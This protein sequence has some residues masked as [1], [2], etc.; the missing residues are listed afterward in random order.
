M[1]DIKPADG[2]ITLKDSRQLC[3]SYFGAQPK[4]G[5]TVLYFHGYLSSRLEAA[6]LDKE[7]GELGLSL[8]AFDRSGYGN[9]YPDP[10]RTP[11]NSVSD[12]QQLLEALIPAEEKVFVFAASGEHS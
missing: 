7:A 3:Y 12:A 8:L 2:I 9:S 4:P 5:R 11:L 10:T 6:L 1:A